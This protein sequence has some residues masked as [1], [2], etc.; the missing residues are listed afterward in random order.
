MRD[1][2][3]P[4]DGPGPARRPASAA[5]RPRSTGLGRDLLSLWP[6]VLGVPALG[7]VA[8]LAVML[9][10]PPD[11]A[12]LGSPTPEITSSAPAGE[13]QRI[14]DALHDIGARCRPGT[15]RPRRAGT[16]ADVDVILSFARRYPEGSFSID[17]ETGTAS[18]LLLV[19]RQ[20]L[21]TCDPR[22]AERVSQALAR[23]PARQP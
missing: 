11:G 14:H 5:P 20:A 9:L 8:L 10:P 18:G 3:P 23:Q 6:V 21:R 19:T 15:S 4:A 12:P 13:V 16:A 1:S 2:R 22:L 17:D 7:L